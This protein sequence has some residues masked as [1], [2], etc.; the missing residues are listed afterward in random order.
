[1]PRKFITVLIIIG[2]I[3][4]CGILSL[5]IYYGQKDETTPFD[6]MMYCKEVKADDDI[7]ECEPFTLKGELYNDPDG[8]L[9]LHLEPFVIDG[10]SL[11][12]SGD[13]WVDTGYHSISE[14]LSNKIHHIPT[15][16]FLDPNGNTHSMDIHLSKELDYCIIAVYD[17]YF[18]GST[19]PDFDAEAIMEL[20]VHQSITE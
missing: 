20:Y 1:M 11:N 4:A 16:F 7:V 6:V 18:V 9:L 17:R 12:T 10:L 2:L 15:A 19:D 3:L 8:D 5:T 14:D 13:A